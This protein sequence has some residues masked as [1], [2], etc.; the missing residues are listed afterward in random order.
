M[1]NLLVLKHK[2]QNS[3]FVIPFVNRNKAVEKRMST[4]MSWARVYDKDKFVEYQNEF[5]EG[6]EFVDCVE[7]VTTSANHFEIRHPLG[8]TF[9]IQA[10]TVIDII[11]NLTI[12]NG[13]IQ[14]NVKLG[15]P[16]SES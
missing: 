7:R 3:F 8:F 6:F 16:G 12:V 9:E 14:E 15:L 1:K 11:R 2:I 4:A 10:R 5:M 13:V